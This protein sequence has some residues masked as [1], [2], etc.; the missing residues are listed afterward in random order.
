M[1]SHSGET[2]VSTGRGRSRS[3][4]VFEPTDVGRDARR[5]RSRAPSRGVLSAER[6]GLTAPFCSESFP[7]SGCGRRT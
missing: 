1:M 4:N 6:L 5:V 3:R 7:R 2:L